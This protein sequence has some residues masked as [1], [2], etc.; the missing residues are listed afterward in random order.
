MSFTKV[1]PAGGFAYG[2]KVSSAA[3]NQLD[4]DHANALDKSVAGD[5]L[6]GVVKMASTAAV[7]VNTVGAA[8][9]VSVGNGFRATA[10]GAVNVTTAGGIQ[11]N[12][13]GGIEAQTPGGIQP[14]ISGGIQGN[15]A[16]GIQATIANG[17]NSTVANGIA[18]G[19]AGGI[20]DG[21]IAGG[22][23]TTVAG[24]FTL[25]G[26]STDWPAFSTAR[27]R[28]NITHVLRAAYIPVNWGQGPGADPFLLTTSVNV[29]QAYCP[30]D[31][32][33]MGGTMI[34]LQV[35]FMVGQSHTGVPATMP[36]FQVVRY[37][38]IGGGSG[39]TSQNLFSGGSQSLSSSWSN[40]VGSWTAPATGSA[41]YDGGVTQVV[42][43][44][45][46][47]NNVLSGRYH[48]MLL[49]SDEQGSNALSGNIYLTYEP[50][51]NNISNMAFA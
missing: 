16:S 28:N 5:T 7:E 48:Y 8:I 38:T 13:A 4:A 23:A 19:V 27:V 20:G 39:T 15:V 43:L 10:S 14:G 9:I 21:G 1:G 37:D 22:I 25:G 24:G 34:A 2:S 17:I 36:T 12:A 3:F 31:F 33:H 32:L 46:D 45:C 29:N 40:S 49:I 18:P 30:L 41:W 44:T 51:I 26:G 6:Q 42:T 35:N 47:Q 11:S 50:Y